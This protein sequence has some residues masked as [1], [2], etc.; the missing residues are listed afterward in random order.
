MATPARAAAECKV[1]AGSGGGTGAVAEG[2]GGAGNEAP[3]RD[4]RRRRRYTL[5]PSWLQDSI[6]KIESFQV[7]S[8]AVR[9]SFNILGE[10]FNAFD[11][12]AAEAAELE[13]EHRARM[14]AGPPPKMT[15][16]ELR[17]AI[18]ARAASHLL[19]SMP[20]EILARVV[21]FF[22]LFDVDCLFAVGK[23]FRTSLQSGEVW[24]D[25]AITRWAIS[26]SDVA[27][28]GVGANDR[29]FDAL[30]EQQQQQQQQEEA[31][32]LTA[33]SMRASILRPFLYL[34][35]RYRHCQMRSNMGSGQLEDWA[36]LISGWIFLTAA[37]SDW[38]SRRVVRQSGGV[39]F[40]V[41][42]CRHDS[43]RIKTLALASLA[44][45]LAT[46]DAR[47]NAMWARNLRGSRGA[48]VFSGMMVSPSSDVQ[49]SSS[50]E[51]SRAL[52]NLA[53][54][55]LA[56]RCLL[57]EVDAA[58]AG[59]GASIADRGGAFLPESAVA[60]TA[61]AAVEAA[62]AAAAAAASAATDE[63]VQLSWWQQL[64]QYQQ[65]EDGGSTGSWSLDMTFQ[66]GGLM[67]FKPKHIVL[68]HRQGELKGS[69]FAFSDG[70]RGRIMDIRGRYSFSHQ[71]LGLGEIHFTLYERP[72]EW[73]GGSG[74]DD[75]AAS[76]GRA[77]HNFRGFCSS[78]S[79]GYWGVWENAAAT[80]SKRRVALRGGGVFRLC[81]KAEEHVAG[82]VEEAYRHK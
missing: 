31:T 52:A 48:K 19:V 15:Q 38:R 17:A 68:R 42:L 13:R 82:A 64:Q 60:A 56:V 36:E 26:P 66:S 55:H 72:S 41:G 4:C 32:W 51:A 22:D 16:E 75:E 62:A 39:R 23:T 34:C 10:A 63:R 43:H 27:V 20:T 70:E 18:T 6:T 69:C 65:R 45:A 25:W 49:S 80:G 11:A 8:D 40:L 9:A 2:G 78:Q 33:C 67:P 37:T 59:G 53:L 7:T 29:A 44:N 5:R 57:W 21:V 73:V 30:T 74:D 71:F 35:E 28:R 1:A 12:R 54:P 81:W 14:I 61:A 47:E 3:P 50:R 58:N 24:R 46:T 77:L 79:R 76:V